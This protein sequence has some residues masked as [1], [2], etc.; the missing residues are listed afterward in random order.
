MTRVIIMIKWCKD[1]K[2]IVWERCFWVHS[3]VEA[4][5]QLGLE[6]SGLK[7]WQPCGTEDAKSGVCSSV[8][9][10]T[11]GYLNNNNRSFRLFDSLVVRILMYETFTVRNKLLVFLKNEPVFYLKSFISIDPRD[12]AGSVKLRHTQAPFWSLYITS[13]FLVPWF[14]T[15]LFGPVTLWVGTS[16]LH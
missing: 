7:L 9:H 6:L 1:K 11:L 10:E 12:G 2:N 5:S 14:Y 13:L 3:A 16:T 15:F 8:S 4:W